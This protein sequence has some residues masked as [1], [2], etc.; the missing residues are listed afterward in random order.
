MGVRGS[1]EHTHSDENDWVRK[2]NPILQQHFLGEEH[3][4][5]TPIPVLRRIRGV[6]QAD[7]LE[8]VSRS[9][10][11]SDPVGGTTRVH[12]QFRASRRMGTSHDLASLG[13]TAI[14]LVEDTSLCAQ[15]SVQRFEEYLSL[16]E[17]WEDYDY[18]LF[19]HSI[20]AC[21]VLT[22]DDS[23]CCYEAQ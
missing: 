15:V 12:T 22:H 3:S 20:T 18:Y 2:M 13:E 21:V 16:K 9:F 10:I 7:I 14:L 19:N 1:G 5:E 11:R 8:T 17:P 23:W 4:F 6:E